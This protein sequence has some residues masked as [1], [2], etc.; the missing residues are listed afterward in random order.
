MFR[1]LKRSRDAAFAAGLKKQRLLRC[2]LRY[3]AP[4]SVTHMG[5]NNAAPPIAA[6]YYTVPLHAKDVANI[7]RHSQLA[8]LGI[9]RE[10]HMRKRVTLLALSLAK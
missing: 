3:A 4:T 5:N 9:P 8:C 1:L 10:L 7:F 6:D 2:V